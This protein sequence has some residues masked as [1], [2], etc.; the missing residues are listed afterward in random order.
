MAIGM[1]LAWGML[2][3]IN[4]AHFGLILLSGYLTYELAPRASA[5]IRC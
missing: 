2:K 4:L 1:T 3:V 5:S